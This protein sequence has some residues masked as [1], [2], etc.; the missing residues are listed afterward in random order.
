MRILRMMLADEDNN[1][2]YSVRRNFDFPSQACVSVA[3]RLPST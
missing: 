3:I 1:E 2:F